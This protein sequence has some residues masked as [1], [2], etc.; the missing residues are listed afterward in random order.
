M[1]LPGSKR[2]ETFPNLKIER[3]KIE[4][5]GNVLRVSFLFLGASW[6]HSLILH[7]NP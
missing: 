3:K 7:K 1:Y 6:I 5:V 2:P 4:S